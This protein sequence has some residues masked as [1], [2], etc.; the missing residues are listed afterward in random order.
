MEACATALGGADNEE[1]PEAAFED[2]EPA[3]EPELSADRPSSGNEN[4]KSATRRERAKRI[5]QMIVTTK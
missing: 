3:P 2:R 1:V 5:I 4:I